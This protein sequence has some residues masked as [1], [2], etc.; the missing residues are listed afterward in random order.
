MKTEKKKKSS[1]KIEV[2]FSRNQVKTKKKI[3][4]KK[5][6][7]AILDYIQPEF[8]GFIRAGWLLIVWSSSAQISMGERLNLDREM[9]NFDGG[10]RP[11]YN[12]STDQSRP[13]FLETLIKN[14]TCSYC[15]CK[16]SKTKGVMLCVC[17]VCLKEVLQIIKSEVYP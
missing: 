7:N 5:V 10:T 13:K 9:L 15:A 12:L 17:V 11:P 3:K 8:V 4:W 6:F 1:P 2:F 14:T 16:S